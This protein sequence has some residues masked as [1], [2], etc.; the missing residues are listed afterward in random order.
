MVPEP[1][2]CSVTDFHHG[3]MSTLPYL[4]SMTAVTGLEE[5][6][7]K[8]KEKMFGEVKSKRWYKYKVV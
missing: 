8:C 3:A 6:N 2:K 1:M 4:L 7:L 5:K